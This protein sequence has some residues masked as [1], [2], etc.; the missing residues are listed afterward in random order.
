LPA[1]QYRPYADPVGLCRFFLTFLQLTSKVQE[2]TLFT[3]LLV[4]AV[5]L[6]FLSV[7][8]SIWIFTASIGALIMV[9]MFPILLVLMVLGVAAFLTFKYF[10]RK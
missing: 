10:Y 5:V 8:G 1:S 7:S 3:L 9:K 4:F 2:D 6:I